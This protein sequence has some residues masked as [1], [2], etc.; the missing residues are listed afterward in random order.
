MRNINWGRAF[1][2]GLIAG[3]VILA[4]EMIFHANIKGADWWFF[5]ALASPVQEARSILLYV[6]RYVLVGLTAVW[7]YVAVR[8]RFGKGPKTAIL[9]GVAYWVIGYLLPVWGLYY[10]ILPGFREEF[11]RAPALV[12]LIEV[13]L[14][15]LAGAWYYAEPERSA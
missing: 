7:L 1:V 4:I 11:L 14:G 12:A 10:L 15:T 5:Q 2:G 3:A 8:P 9:T 6:G 13:V